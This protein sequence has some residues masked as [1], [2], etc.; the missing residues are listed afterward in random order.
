MKN[1]QQKKRKYTK[2]QVTARK[3]AKKMSQLYN[4]GEVSAEDAY[5]TILID[6][7][8]VH[9]LPTRIQQLESLRYKL[10]N[11]LITETEA[12]EKVGEIEKQIGNFV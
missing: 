6:I 4:D 1:K 8:K 10:H 3:T 7:C 9:N 12:L 5:I 2:K 11:G